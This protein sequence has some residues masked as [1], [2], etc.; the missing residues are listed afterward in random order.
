MTLLATAHLKGPPVDF[1]G[2]APLIA[3]LG[4]AVVALLAG[5]LG[6]RRVREHVVPALFL[7]ALGAAA[8]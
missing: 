1:A 6:S 4:G 8:G 2:L 5:L 7:V 3:L